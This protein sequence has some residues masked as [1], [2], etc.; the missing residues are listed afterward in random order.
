MF[1]CPSF[2]CI[3]PSRSHSQLVVKTSSDCCPSSSYYNRAST[4]YWMC[5][6]VILFANS[7]HTLF[8]YEMIFLLSTQHWISSEWIL[9]VFILCPHWICDQCKKYFARTTPSPLSM[10]GVGTTTGYTLISLLISFILHFSFLSCFY[11]LI[12][13]VKYFSNLIC[14]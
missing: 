12:F 6:Y 4:R 9:N 11:L 7:N 14:L 10:S 3:E 5:F 13:N 8:D 2:S 1:D